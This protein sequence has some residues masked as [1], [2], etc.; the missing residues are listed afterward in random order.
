LFWR[1]EE[2]VKWMRHW[3]YLF[4]HRLLHWS[5]GRAQGDQICFVKNRPKCSPNHILSN[6]MRNIFSEKVAQ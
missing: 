6:L 5:E 3:I 2:A 4:A 1:T